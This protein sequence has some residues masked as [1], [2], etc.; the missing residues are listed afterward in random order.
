MLNPLNVPPG[1]PCGLCLALVRNLPALNCFAPL[2]SAFCVELARQTKRQYPL[3]YCNEDER[4][5]SESRSLEFSK[6]RT[7]AV[8]QGEMSERICKCANGDRG[9]IPTHQWRRDGKHILAKQRTVLFVGRKIPSQGP[10][11]VTKKT[12]LERASHFWSR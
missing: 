11:P 2:N 12:K 10:T 6:Q 8:L 9:A 7:P 1:T 5:G 4:Q 3:R